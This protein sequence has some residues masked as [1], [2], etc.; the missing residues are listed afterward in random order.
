[1]FSVEDCAV[2]A[3][4]ADFGLFG[5]ISTASRLHRGSDFSVGPKTP[6]GAHASGPNLPALTMT[7][8]REVCTF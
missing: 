1:M 7:S 5:H 3:T 4:S 2:C 8:V 6:G